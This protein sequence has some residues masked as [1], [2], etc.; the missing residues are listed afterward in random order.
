MARETRV[1]LVIGLAFIICFALILA[2]RGQPRQLTEHIPYVVDNGGGM[3][4][5]FG[6]DQ[7]PVRDRDAGQPH[8]NANRREQARDNRVSPGESS[9][10]TTASRSAQRPVPSETTQPRYDRD[11][12]NRAINAGRTDDEPVR[13]TRQLSQRESLLAD[14]ARRRN[15]QDSVR[16][17]GETPAGASL[18]S[19]S[20]ASIES[21]LDNLGAAGAL[22]GNNRTAPP[23]THSNR[24][25]ANR[26]SRQRSGRSAS[27][28][29][30]QYTVKSGDSLSK[31]AKTHY[32]TASTAVMQ[33]VYA[34]NRTVMSSPDMVRIDDVLT[35]PP[36]GDRVANNASRSSDRTAR[37]AA[38]D[39]PT[40]RTSKG[41]PATKSLTPINWYQVRPNDRY[42]SIA[43]EQL[44]DGGRWREI[45]ELN[46]T[47]FPDPDR[48][49][50]GVR[51]M[52][53]SSG[54]SRN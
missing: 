49:R 31:I 47:K 28:R 8:V 48:I 29:S 20:N 10:H 46:K 51:I 37:R 23:P 34:A 45:F 19:R 50:V 22:N 17:G 52:L 6:N 16:R 14:L 7:L 2:K 54:R 24:N 53:P 41:R 18:T 27:A 12:T 26:R 33:A 13:S 11:G 25:T 15:Q 40:M 32:G 30:S 21:I 43:R 35:L 42:V 3:T 4:R 36:I 9:S 1:G 5:Q 44:G 39:K 38:T